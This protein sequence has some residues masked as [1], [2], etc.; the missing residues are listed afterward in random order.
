M[1]H[2]PGKHEVID[3]T[4]KG[5]RKQSDI[6]K[7]V[8]LPVEQE[9]EPTPP[10]SLTSE[11]LENYCIQCIASTGD[12]QKRRVFAKLVQ[13]IKEH[14]EMK[15]ELRAYKLKELRDSNIEETPDDIQE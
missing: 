3:A 9:N 12:Q 13:I 10:A 4:F 6:L 15:K 1:P 7:E 8:D 11:Q 5:G 14:E 2:I